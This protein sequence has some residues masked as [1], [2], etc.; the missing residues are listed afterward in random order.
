M[1]L[2]RGRRVPASSEAPGLIHGRLGLRREAGGI[3][4]HGEQPDAVIR[5]RGDKNEVGAMPVD[6]ERLAAGQPPTAGIGRGNTGNSEVP[7]AASRRDR[8]RGDAG[9]IDNLRQPALLALVVG[10]QE[11]GVRGENRCREKRHAGERTPEFLRRDT[12]LDYSHA[13]TPVLLRN[14]DALQAELLR[15]A[16]PQLLVDPGITRHHPADIGLSRQCG[17][18]AP[19]HGPELVLLIGVGEVHPT[20]LPLTGTKP[21]R[22]RAGRRRT[23]AERKTTVAAPVRSRCSPRALPPPRR[24]RASP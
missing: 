12:E 15:H 5:P 1:S 7:V 20:L 14:A 13:R 22:V 9:A 3:P 16:E 10:G 19:D 6:N 2:S 8:D 24:R 4:L 23:M 21:V 11:Q 18:K 17:E